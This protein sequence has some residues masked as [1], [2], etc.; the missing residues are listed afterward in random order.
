MLAVAFLSAEL[1]LG[2]PSVAI[3]NLFLYHLPIAVVEGFGTILLYDILTAEVK[4]RT[5]V[6]IAIVILLFAAAPLASASP[7]AL[8]TV[9]AK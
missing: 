8:E 1:M 5:A 9:L 7:D 6:S 4:Y 2:G 3:A